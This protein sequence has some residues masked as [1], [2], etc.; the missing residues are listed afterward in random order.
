[1]WPHSLKRNGGHRLVKKAWQVV[2]PYDNRLYPLL[3]AA[4]LNETMVKIPP[5]FASYLAIVIRLKD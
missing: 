1:M 2:L 5:R 4:N 3:Q